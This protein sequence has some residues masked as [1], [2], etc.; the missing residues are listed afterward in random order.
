MVKIDACKHCKQLD[1]CKIRT[2]PFLKSFGHGYVTNVFKCEI[3]GQIWGLSSG[4]GS[5]IKKPEGER[6]TDFSY[7]L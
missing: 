7:D 5:W 3:C 1:S 2:H 6:V 4:S